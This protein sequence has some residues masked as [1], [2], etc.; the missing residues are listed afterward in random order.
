MGRQKYV[1]CYHEQV[2]G[3]YYLYVRFI[4]HGYGK[5]IIQTVSFLPRQVALTLP[6]AGEL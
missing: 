1:R 4:P 3:G 6:H 5:D 2:F